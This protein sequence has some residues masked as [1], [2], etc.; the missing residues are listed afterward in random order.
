MNYDHPDALEHRLLA[1]HLDALRAGTG[2]DVPRYDYRQH[3]RCDTSDHVAPAPVIIVEGI[4][5]LSD[6]ALRR[7]FDIR[8][9]M[10]TPLDICLLRRI[11]RDLRE[12][13][14][15]LGSI[16]D[17]YER[18][19]RPMYQQ[20]IAPSAAHA[21]MLITGGGLNAVALGVVC[22]LVLSRLRGSAATPQ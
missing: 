15:D 6:P 22:D 14:R 3:T 21:D 10:D 2:V 8:F 5:L 4:L 19:V 9:F 20:Y 13:G 11:G 1:E 16:T 18:S 17:Q 12:R 7:R